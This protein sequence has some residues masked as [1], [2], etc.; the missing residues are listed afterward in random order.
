MYCNMK[1][2]KEVALLLCLPITMF[3][4]NVVLENALVK[5][6]F[7]LREQTGLST[8]FYGMKNIEQNYVLG[9]NKEFSFR[10]NDKEFSGLS[11]WEIS[12][13]DTC[14]YSKSKGVVFTLHSKELEGLSI[15]VVYMAYEDIPVVKKQISFYNNGTKNLKLEALDIENFKIGWSERETWVMRYYGRY[16]HVGAYVG[17]WDDPVI[18]LHDLDND[19]GIAV[20]NEVPGVIKRISAL[21]DGK[22]VTS[23]LTHPEQTFGFRKWI[24]P[25]EKWHSPAVFTALYSNTSDPYVV[26]NTSVSDYVRKYMGI[27]YE[28][29]P[30]KPMFVYNTWFPFYTNINQNLI[31]ELADAAS[32]CGVEEFIIDDGWQVC[33][34][35]WQVNKEKFPNGLKPVFSHI[36]SLG[37]KPG[38]WVTVS[39]AQP[40]SQVYKDHQEWFVEDKNGNKANLH[41]EHPGDGLTA[42]M[43]TDWK[44]HL[45]QV[46]LRL[47][48]EHGLVY[49]KLD[50]AIATSAYV[51]DLERTGCYSGKHPFHRDHEESYGVIYERCMQLF[52]ELH[53]ESPELF[54]DCTYETAGK[55]QLNDYGIIKYAEGN[56]LSNIQQPGA[57][58][59][60][61]ARLLA[62]QRCPALP[63]ST[64][65]IGNLKMN[66]E[67]H[68]LAF[69]SLAGT[70]P[71]MLGDPRAL[72]DR[73]KRNYKQWS[74]W[75]KGLE[76]RHSYTS[77][78]Q[79]LPGFGEP[80]EGNWDGFSRIN[81]ETQSG[82]LVGVFKQGAA[83][84]KRIVTVRYLNP[85]KQYAIK[86]G[87]T[88]KIITIMSGKDLEKK[89]FE[90]RLN[91]KYDGALFEIMVQ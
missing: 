61:R 76:K 67:E 7:N 23:G 25:G 18:T 71:V 84:N 87:K 3:S 70:L 86:E 52:N 5:R 74:D 14:E 78:R 30:Q 26:L 22:S 75:L 54:I 50:F 19:K 64:L 6:V 2:L 63:A 39:M 90:V 44:D 57:K 27:R 13:K 88:G 35:D 49:S 40:Y 36:K 29:L 1:N 45:K 16:K 9:G 12:Y 24:Y 56:W 69:K 53:K 55:M 43:G 28:K 77:F 68:E 34:G 46:V 81:T 42:C 58:G 91:K 21:V 31:T 20:G 65:V 4:Q 80:A 17:D 47:I 33:H 79:D 15:Q 8:D 72:S 48:K 82:G 62:W 66:D 41:T 32:S 38:L 51:Y 11:R 10:V 59:A 37:M 60:F 89:G 83:E 73:E 85:Q